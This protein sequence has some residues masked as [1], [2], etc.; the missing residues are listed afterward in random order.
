MHT[1]LILLAIETTAACPE[2]DLL[3]GQKLEFMGIL[4]ELYSKNVDCYPQIT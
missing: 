3:Y 1:V 4:L 2:Q